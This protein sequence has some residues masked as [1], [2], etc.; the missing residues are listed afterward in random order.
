[1]NDELVLKIRTVFPDDDMDA[2]YEAVENGLLHLTVE[3]IDYPND[4][5]GTVVMGFRISPGAA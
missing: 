5:D 2:A 1:M 4:T 3:A